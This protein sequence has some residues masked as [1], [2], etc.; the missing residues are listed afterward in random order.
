MTSPS[1]IVSVLTLFI[2]LNFYRMYLRMLTWKKNLKQSFSANGKYEYEYLCCWYIKSTLYKTSL[3]WNKTFKKI[4][5]ATGKT[6]FFVIDAFCTPHHISLNIGSWKK[7]FVYQ[8]VCFK[9]IVLKTFKLFSD[10]HIK[11]SWSVNPILF[12]DKGGAKM[13]YPSIFFKYLQIYLLNWLEIIFKVWFSNCLKAVLKNLLKI[14]VRKAL[15]HAL[16]WMM[17]Y[18]KKSLKIFFLVFSIIFHFLSFSCCVC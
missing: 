8:K 9:V 18:W 2:D 10:C 17:S 4:K 5:Y 6:P 11:R 7:A 15:D 1:N 12:G 16:S 13:P 14:G 3:T